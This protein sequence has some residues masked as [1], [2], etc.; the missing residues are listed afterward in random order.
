MI[1]TIYYTDAYAEAPNAMETIVVPDSGSWSRTRVHFRRCDKR[2]SRRTS[3]FGNPSISLRLDDS[4]EA[5]QPEWCLAIETYQNVD[6]KG[7]GWYHTK[8]H[9][10]LKH[11]AATQDDYFEWL[12]DNVM[13]VYVDMAPYWTNPE[14][15]SDVS[16]RVTDTN[17]GFSGGD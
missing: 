5:S 7:Y 4:K 10:P 16:D 8:G 9:L 13:A 17:T 14:Y 3:N 15:A 12:M 2:A 11:A 1:I 6:G